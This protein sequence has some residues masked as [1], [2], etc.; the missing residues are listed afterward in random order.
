MKTFLTCVFILLAV[1]IATADFMGFWGY[2]YS[3][4]QPV[5][6]AWVRIINTA[7]QERDSTQTNDNGRYYIACPGHK[8]YDMKAWKG[9]LSQTKLNQYNNGQQGDVQV[10]FDL[11]DDPGE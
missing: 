4:S 1:R 11:A 9:P 10:D 2:V 5:S 6:G 7:T 3:G 8:Y